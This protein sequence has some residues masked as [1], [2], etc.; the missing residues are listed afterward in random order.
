MGLQY[1]VP[2]AVTLIGCALLLVFSIFLG[3]FAVATFNQSE[4]LER[5]TLAAR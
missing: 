4:S 2:A 5:S 3:S 1:G